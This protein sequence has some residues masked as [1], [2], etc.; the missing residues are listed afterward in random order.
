MNRCGEGVIGR[1]GAVDVVVGVH[2]FVAS[3]GLAGCL[4]GQVADHLI[5]VHVGLRAAAGL[6]DP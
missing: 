2:R 3:Q 5:E 6:P 1:L 4:R